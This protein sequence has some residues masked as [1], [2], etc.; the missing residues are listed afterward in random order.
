MCLV[1]PWLMA[2]PPVACGR[3]T[4]QHPQRQLRQSASFAL[5][6]ARGKGGRRDGLLV[7]QKRK[8][9]GTVL[10]QSQ[11][12]LSPKETASGTLTSLR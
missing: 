11:T 6:M 4:S 7:G 8:C 2:P 12:V 9:T 5:G 10:V 1:G 3:L